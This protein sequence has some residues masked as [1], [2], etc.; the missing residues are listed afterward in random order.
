MAIELELDQVFNPEIGELVEFA[1]SPG[2]VY[3]VFSA[4]E[5]S[6]DLEGGRLLVDSPT[7]MLPVAMAALISDNS[8]VL[9]IAGVQYQSHE[10]GPDIANLVTL[11]LT[12]D[13]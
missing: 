5:E 4:V 7:I 10:R 6:V 3:G 8:T 12:R 9:T 13:F 1:G 11:Y 2:N